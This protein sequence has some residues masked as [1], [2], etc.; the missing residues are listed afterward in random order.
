MSRLTN[1]PF[2]KPSPFQ[3]PRVPL[4]PPET[5]TEQFP[6][7]SLSA[8]ISVAGGIDGLPHVEPDLSRSQGSETPGS[9]FRRGVSSLAYH[10][11]GLRDARE[12]GVSRNYRYFV[13]IVPPPTFVHDHG[14][15]GHTLSLGPQNR[16]SQGLLM[17]LF[18]TVSPL[19]LYSLV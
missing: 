4:S 10:N 19:W 2:N 18:P 8:S 12:R 14:Q 13:I 3:F 17:P 7:S 1:S 16:L 9:R 6:P 11:S 15:L 5:S